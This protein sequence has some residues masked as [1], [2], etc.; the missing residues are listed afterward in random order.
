ME[1]N[2]GRV[3]HAA[4]AFAMRAAAAKDEAKW[5]AQ[6]AAGVPVRTTGMRVVR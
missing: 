2:V 6:R 4:L 3:D 1:Y 5:E